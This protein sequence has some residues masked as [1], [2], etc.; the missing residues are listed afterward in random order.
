MLI[1]TRRKRVGCLQRSRR[2]SFFHVHLSF[3][4]SMH[5]L[6]HLVFTFQL[7]DSWNKRCLA[8]GDGC[9][10]RSANVLPLRG[11]HL[12]HSDYTNFNTIQR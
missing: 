12:G 2:G 3:L 4:L 1:Q 10:Q 8:F 7:K 9:T 5:N 11:A 6:D